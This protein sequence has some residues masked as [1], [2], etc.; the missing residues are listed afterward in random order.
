MTGRDLLRLIG[1]ARSRAPRPR[2]NESGA[3]A[4][5]RVALALAAALAAAPS[6]ASAAIPRWTPDG[7]PL[8]TA[9]GIQQNPQLTADGAGGAIVTWQ[10]RR[11]NNLDDVYAQRV[12][13][14]G[15][16]DP[17]WPLNGVALC[18]AP[19]NQSAPQIATDGAGGAIVAWQDGRSNGINDI[20]AQHVLAS[21]VVDPAWPTDGLVLCAASGAQGL[22]QIATDGAGGA[23]VAWQ[24][25][26]NGTSDIYAQHVLSTGVVDPAW[27]ADGLVVCVAVRT[28]TN[29]RMV[30]DGAGGAL[31]TWQDSR[32]S[33]PGFDVYDIYAQRLLATGAPAPGWP[34]NGAAVCTNV[35]N[36]LFPEIA[37]DGA[38]GAIV[39]WYDRR[40][41]QPAD[42]IFQDIFAQRISASGVP[43]WTPDG[44]RI[45]TA[46]STQLGQVI[47]ADG[48]GGAIVA[49]QDFRSNVSYDLYAQHVRADS[50]IVPGWPVNGV[51]LSSA[52]SSQENPRIVSDGAGGA[53]VTWY[54]VI[55]P[56]SFGPT[57]R[58]IYAQRV[59]ANGAIAPGWPA[60]GLVVCAADS[61]QQTPQ[62]AS[63]GAG[64]AIVTWQ[65]YRKLGANPQDIY[66]QRINDTPCTAPGAA[67]EVWPLQSCGVV[68]WTR[69]AGG[70][71]SDVAN[72]NG[73]AGPVPNGPC[74]AT[75]TLYDA[76]FGIG[77]STYGIDFSSDVTSASV[78]VAVGDRAAFQLAG[79][80]YAT[81]DLRIQDAASRLTVAGGTLTVDGAIQISQVAADAPSRAGGARLAGATPGSSFRAEA[82][83][84]AT[85]SGGGSGSVLFAPGGALVSA[86]PIPY[87]LTNS[88]TLSPGAEPD[89]IGRIEST[90]GYVQMPGATLAIDLGGPAPGTG[91]DQ[92]RV[93]G[94]ATLAGT[95]R[96]KLVGGYLPTIGQE[97]E[98]LIA[99]PRIGVF[100]SVAI[101]IGVSYT[102]TSV[103]LVTIPA[104][105]A[106][107]SLV[108]AE[109]EPGRVKVRWWV[110]D[111]SAPVGIERARAR[112]GWETVAT[113]LPDGTGM[114]SYEDDGVTPGRYGYRLRLASDGAEIPAG[115]VWVEVPAASAFALRGVSP[116]PAH[117]PLAVTF[118][119]GNA[120]PAALELY[121]LAGRRLE[122]RAIEAPRPGNRVLVLAPDA[123]L[124]AGVYLLR[125]TQGAR[126]ASCRFAVVR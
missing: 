37:P 107:A 112:G 48:A 40:S 69:A 57:Y 94:P 11:G 2:M 79:H 111:A 110:S 29:P 123:E 82:G 10:D 96:W 106:L 73:G 99:H 87:D 126:R 119:L 19:F 41:G 81:G 28:Q 17:A 25:P 49:W 3:C 74:P 8:C 39:T 16:V 14:D 26:R 65:D 116:N 122:T 93:A 62:I 52:T 45:C 13:A 21:G 83:T 36:Q 66:A 60:D 54:N 102:D 78:T 101:D 86:A 55:S 109:A 117:G 56:P 59:L 34:A 121:D 108:S 33:S 18:T 89:G 64:G 75:C 103:V 113:V 9:T 27:P 76:R 53:I 92:L 20:Y 77:S 104:T 7:V 71:Y 6:P 80:T 44:I 35:G 15:T 100:D 47:A 30:A 22:P 61:T 4:C 51:A 120:E 42:P 88:G 23:I 43:L 114:V 118:S 72:W 70:L 105:P 5:L 46:V 124:S 67:P 38:G 84:G 1:T 68:D 24:D 115:E 97:F 63:D 12:R 85:L 98:V 32:S 50:T 31:V 91:H 90:A 58:D 125:L 95:L